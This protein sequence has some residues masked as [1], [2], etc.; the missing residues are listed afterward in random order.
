[1]Q[2][3]LEDGLIDMIEI[4]LVP[5]LLGAGLNLLNDSRDARR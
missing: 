3:A 2:S 4:F 1:M 5:V